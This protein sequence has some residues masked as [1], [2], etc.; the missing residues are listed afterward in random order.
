MGRARSR[1]NNGDTMAKA[2]TPPQ[3]LAELPRERDVI[4]FDIGIDTGGR[5]VIFKFVL[6]N[7][8]EELMFLPPGIAFH[9]RDCLRDAI[10][11]HRYRDIRRKAGD[12]KPEVQI[13]QAFRDRQPVFEENDWDAKAGDT[14]RSALGSE[15]HV[16]TNAV[17]LVFQ[18]TDDMYRALRLHPALSYYLVE[19]VNKAEKEG[20]IVDLSKA[21]PPSN[22]KQ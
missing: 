7:G 20:G 12:V 2:K 11:R 3:F 16:Y 18:I 13:V 19:M 10:R 15:V 14:A 9:V 17:F 1:L 4:S 8:T 21:S 6:K 5:C 22:R